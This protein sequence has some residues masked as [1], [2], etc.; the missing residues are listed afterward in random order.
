MAE[1]DW[2]ESEEFKKRVR[3]RVAERARTEGV[4]FE[5]S[6]PFLLTVYLDNYREENKRGELLKEASRQR[7][8]FD[9][10]ASVDALVKEAASQARARGSRTIS[11]GDMQRAQSA[12]F[13]MVW[14]FCGKGK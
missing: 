11:M 8:Q 4:E 2:L 10:Y 7:G 1:Y 13:C 6:V 5:S 9:A 3:E 12:K 14:P